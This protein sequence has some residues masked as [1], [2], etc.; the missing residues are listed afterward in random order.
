MGGAERDEAVIT[1]NTDALVIL[2]VIA[3]LAAGAVALLRA[4]D[5]VSEPKDSGLRCPSC[6]NGVAVIEATEPSVMVVRCSACGHR[7][8]A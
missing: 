6:R 1:I 4:I 2:S 7:W 5:A 3:V 8:Q